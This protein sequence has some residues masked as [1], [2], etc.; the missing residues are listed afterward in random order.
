VVVMQI[1]NKSFHGLRDWLVQRAT[2]VIMAVYAVVLVAMCLIYKPASYESWKS[3][4][5]ANWLKPMT[6]L[7]LL[8]LFAHAWLGVEA[9]LIDYVKPLRFRQTLQSAAALSLIFY[10]AWSVRILWNA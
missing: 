3:L 10:A 5:G 1:F 2:A 4:M 8:S 9:V 6:L 7:F